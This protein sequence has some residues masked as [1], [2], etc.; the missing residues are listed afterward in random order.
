L[1]CL[2]SI[3]EAELMWKQVLEFDPA[4]QWMKENAQHPKKEER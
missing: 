1:T 3:D 4:L 2:G